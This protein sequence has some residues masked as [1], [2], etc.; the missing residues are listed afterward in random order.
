MKFSVVVPV[1][2]GERY[3]SQCLLSV[4]KQTSSDFELI[5]VDDGSTDESGF[6]ADEFA[7][8]YHNV[9]VLHGPN[10]GLLLARRRGLSSCQGD[11]VIFLDGDDLLSSNA[12]EVIS[13]TIDAT[14]ADIISFRFSR[15]C[16]LSTSDDPVSMDAGFYDGE[17]YALVK[18]AVLRARF[19]NLCGKALRLCCIDVGADYGT[20][21]KLM[22]AE[23]L[24]QLLPIIDESSS[25]ARIDDVLYYYRPNGAGS[26]G[27]YK[28]SYLTD[29]ECVARRLFEYGAK[30]G[31][32][33]SALDGAL[34]LYANVLRLLV[35]HCGSHDV[36]RELPLISCSLK[37]L[38]PDMVNG[39]TKLRPD[40]RILLD[41]ALACNAWKVVGSVHATDIARKLTGRK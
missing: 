16:D 17:R 5:V 4:V 26:T 32:P 41:G 31:M 6:I 39:V 38:S 11:Y 8:V 28:H 21:A 12:L 7:A 25:L 18:E 30:W 3:L 1:Y 29:S 2:N 15:R 34:A 36:K 14:D 20:N 9:E 19:N 35:R 22:L 10:Q 24:L 13:K 33:S 40:L 23:D 27:T 37:N